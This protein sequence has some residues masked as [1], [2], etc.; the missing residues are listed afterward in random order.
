MAIRDRVQTCSGDEVGPFMQMTVLGI[1]DGLWFPIDKSERGNPLGIPL[2]SLYN[3]S[4]WHEDV[5]RSS[6][7][8]LLKRDEE[9]H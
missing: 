7:P 2:L 4:G 3:A 5:P 1:G 9:A 8:V 6:S